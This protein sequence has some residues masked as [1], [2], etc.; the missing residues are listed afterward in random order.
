MGSRTLLKFKSICLDTTFQ[1]K[2]KI[3]ICLVRGVKICS[4]VIFSFKMILHIIATQNTDW[5]IC[6]QLGDTCFS[7]LITDNDWAELRQKA[8]LWSCCG[9]WG[10]C[11]A[12]NMTVTT[13]CKS[14]DVRS[15]H[16]ASSTLVSSQAAEL[17]K[18]SYSCSL[19][20]HSCLRQH[21][22]Y[23]N[24]CTKLKEII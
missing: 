12:L 13:L 5:R 17:E 8:R 6:G 10:S 3:N 4:I 1:C 20:A 16:V 19:F 15:L 23:K 21:Q 2:W 22:F 9:C 14:T 18:F 24:K 11:C 7:I